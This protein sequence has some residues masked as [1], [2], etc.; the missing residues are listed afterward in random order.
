MYS[1]AEAA[2]RMG[3]GKSTIR[4]LMSQ[5][6]LESYQIGR[7]VRI[8]EEQIQEYLRKAKR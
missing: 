1:V 5:G 6:E 8:S 7:A 2:K 3:I 4:K